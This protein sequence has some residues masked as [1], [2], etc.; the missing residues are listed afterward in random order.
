MQ[1]TG[2]ELCRILEAHGWRQ[3]RVKGSHHIFEKSGETRVI[4]VPVHG[5]K[6]LK[7]GLAAR[8]LQQAGIA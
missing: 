1:G 7:K 6:T 3:V 2:R 5:K 4:P 8:I